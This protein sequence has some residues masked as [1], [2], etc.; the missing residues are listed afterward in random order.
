MKVTS[1]RTQKRSDSTKL[2]G[3]IITWGTDNAYP[4]RLQEIIQSS[5]TGR[6]C[7]DL[8][9][10]FIIGR[11]FANEAVGEQVINSKGLT[12]EK[13]LTE[14]ARDLASLDGV[15]LHFNFNALF[16]IT[17]PPNT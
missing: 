10:K 4:Q 12:W 1:V 8:R 7:V 6:V 3:K 15:A 13:L 16:Q 11:G 9:R 14:N 5:G 2:S 17:V